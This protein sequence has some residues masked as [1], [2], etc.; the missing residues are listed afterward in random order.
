MRK[1]FLPFIAAC[2]LLLVGCSKTENNSDFI[3]FEITTNNNPTN[4]MGKAKFPI[5]S[6]DITQHVTRVSI[7]AF[8]NDNSGNYLYVK[9]YTISDWTDGLNFKRHTVDNSDKLPEGDYK[10]LAVGRDATDLYTITTLSPTTDFED[11][12]ASIAASGDEHEIFAGSTQAQVMTS[13]ARVSINI[14]RKVAGVLGYFKNVPRTLNA[15][16]VRYLR[17]S[18]NQVNRRVNLTTGVGGSPDN[19]SYDIIDIDLGTQN[20]VNGLYEGNDLSSAGV[21]KLANSQLGGAYLIPVGSVSF[22]LGLYNDSNVAIKTWN[23]KS[24]TATTFDLVANNFY[25]LGVKIR[26]NTTTGRDPSD[27]TDNDDAIDLLT[28][29]TISVTISSAWDVINNLTLE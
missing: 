15:Q 18:I 20:V 22:T 21:V 8:K 9:T 25:S 19:N 17:L 11:V 5:Y 23:V 13:G 29:Q 16:T 28:D 1:F 2:A 6:Q 7:H 10:F 12:T 27:L 4:G 14:A 26:A 24:G 3:V